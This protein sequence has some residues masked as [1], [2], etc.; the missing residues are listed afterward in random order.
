MAPHWCIPSWI[1]QPTKH[2]PRLVFRKKTPSW[3]VILSMVGQK[4]I[5]YTR[6]IINWMAVITHML[7]DYFLP[8][9]VHVKSWWQPAHSHDQHTART[10]TIIS[11]NSRIFKPADF[12]KP[13]IYLTIHYLFKN[14]VRYYKVGKFLGLHDSPFFHSWINP[15]LSQTASRIQYQSPS[16]GDSSQFFTS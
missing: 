8:G 4:N 5:S 16:A 13:W 15:D 1:T 10:I 3:S 11:V 2:H 7:Y 14:H 6:H 12:F 9:T